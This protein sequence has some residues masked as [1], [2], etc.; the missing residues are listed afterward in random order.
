MIWFIILGFAALLAYYILMAVSNPA[1][2]RTLLQIMRWSIVVSGVLYVVVLGLELTLV[3]EYRPDV[4]VV[5]SSFGMVWSFGGLF[6]W[7]AKGTLNARDATSR[8]PATG[9]LPRPHE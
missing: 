8:D 7:V 3:E 1:R 9:E 5:Y 6:Y 2:Q 4:R